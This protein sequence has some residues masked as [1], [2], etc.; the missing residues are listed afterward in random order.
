MDAA[1]AEWV[2]LRLTEGSLK[3]ELTLRSCSSLTWSRSERL[4]GGKSANIF[5]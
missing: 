5:I 4:T 1:F 2:R 3:V